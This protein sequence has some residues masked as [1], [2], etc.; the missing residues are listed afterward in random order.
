MEETYENLGM[1][2][3][4]IILQNFKNSSFQQFLQMIVDF[5]CLEKISSSLLRIFVKI[6]H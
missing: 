4:L 6:W 3:Y 5:E 2:E 1:E